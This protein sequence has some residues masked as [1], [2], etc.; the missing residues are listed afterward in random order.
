MVDIDCIISS[1]RCRNGLDY[2]EYSRHDLVL[3]V[4]CASGV[5]DVVW[6]RLVYG[7]YFWTKLRESSSLLLDYILFKYIIIVSYS[8]LAPKAGSKQAS[9]ASMGG[10]NTV[11]VYGD[12]SHLVTSEPSFENP[13]V[14]F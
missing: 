10:Y 14:C 7:D 13:A 2:T 6:G 5:Y 1:H 8:W 12:S 4:T 11:N 9:A 3:Y